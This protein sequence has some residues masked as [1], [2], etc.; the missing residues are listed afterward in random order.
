MMAFMPPPVPI[1][2]GPAYRPA[3]AGPPS[4]V[5]MGLIGRGSWTT[6]L[7]RAVGKAQLAMQQLVYS[8]SGRCPLQLATSL[9]PC[10]AARNAER[11]PRRS[12]P[13]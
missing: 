6:Y 1:G 3:P 4:L 12:T 5:E 11:G 10:V 2:V 7:D 13:R 9:A 8:V